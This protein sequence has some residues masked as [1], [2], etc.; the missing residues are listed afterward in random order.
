MFAIALRAIRRL[1]PAE[2]TSYGLTAPQVE[3]LTVR[4]ESWADEIDP[5][6]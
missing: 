4:I 6:T 5:S 3:A 2:F 1:P